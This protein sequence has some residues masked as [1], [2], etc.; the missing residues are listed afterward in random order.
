MRVKA[1]TSVTQAPLPSRSRQVM[2]NGLRV[3]QTLMSDVMSQDGKKI[4][5][6]GTQITSDLLGKL[7]NSASS[8]GIMEPILAKG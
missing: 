6:A 3:G 2:F 1:I 7:K 8:G 4:V 5:A